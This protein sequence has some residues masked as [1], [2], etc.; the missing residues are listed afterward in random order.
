M[1]S[2]HKASRLLWLSMALS[3]GR[4]IT[5]S[6]VRE[7]FGV[8]R[9]TAKRYLIELQNNIPHRIDG[10]GKTAKRLNRPGRRVVLGVSFEDAAQ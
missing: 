7:R 1:D 10:G 3:G 5:S 6:Y 8:S 2:G 4:E 9:A